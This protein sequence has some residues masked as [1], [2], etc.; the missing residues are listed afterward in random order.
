MKG[1]D[2]SDYC[3]GGTAITSPT[4]DGIVLVGCFGQEYIYQMVPLQ[5]GTYVWKTMKQK[6]EYG[7]YFPLLDYIDDSLVNCY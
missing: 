3:R 4:G 5:N 6:L 1:P 2:R 7:K